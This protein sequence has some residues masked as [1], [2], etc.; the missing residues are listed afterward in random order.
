[1]K[2]YIW[3]VTYLAIMAIGSSRVWARGEVAPPPYGAGLG[4]AGDW[5]PG[6]SL[7]G[8]DDPFG[9]GGID[10]GGHGYGGFGWGF[11]GG[12]GRR[13]PDHLPGGGWNWNGILGG[14]SG[15]GGGT[16]GGSGGG[17]TGGGGG[18]DNGPT[19]DSPCS[20]CLQ[21]VCNYDLA[22]TNGTWPVTFW[23][24]ICY[25]MTKPSADMQIGDPVT[26]FCKRFG[27]RSNGIET[28]CC[29]PNGSC[30]GTAGQ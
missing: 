7:F 13:D 14:G 9:D 21:Q 24:N 16:G 29:I 27:S 25:C 20:G 22:T 5:L 1:M 6:G 10:G 18:E 28:G 3:L 17:G 2:I 12:I 26:G 11:G 30:N 15:G 8:F 4:N 23:A 19:A